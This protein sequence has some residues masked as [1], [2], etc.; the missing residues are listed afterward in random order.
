[1]LLPVC[2]CLSKHPMMQ[3]YSG[4]S[5]E[6]YGT[7]SKDEFTS[8]FIKGVEQGFVEA[9]PLNFSVSLKI[10]FDTFKRAWCRTT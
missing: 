5:N 9:N 3:D 1:M 7:V 10:G 4:Q 2:A 8:Q 6:F